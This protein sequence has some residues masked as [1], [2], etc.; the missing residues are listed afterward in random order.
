M[1][2]TA[3]E[4]AELA[5]LQG[6]GGAGHS[7][8]S[9][10]EHA[11]LQQLQ[12]ELPAQGTSLASKAMTGLKVGA[13]VL[14]YQRGAGSVALD[15][16]AQHMG[17]KPGMTDQQA[18]AALDPTS[19][20]VAPSYRELLKNW[21][22]PAGPSSKD[23]PR[24]MGILGTIAQHMP[25]VTARDAAGTGM[26]MGLDPMMYEGGALGKIAKMTEGVPYLGKAADAVSS[27]PSVA[28][29]ALKSGAKS[30]YESGIQPIIQA[31]KRFGNPDVGDTMMKHGIWGRP[32]SILKD[33]GET[34]GELKTSRDA[35][36]RAA[37]GLGATASKDDAITPMFQKLQQMV[38]DQRM[39]GPDAARILQDLTLSKQH[40]GDLVSPE[41]MT[42][43]KTDE[44][45]ALPGATFDAL[46]AR[47]PT[48]AQEI[49]RTLQGGYKNE[50]ERSVSDVVG[51]A[52]GQEFS[53]TNQELGDLINKKVKAAATGMANKH[54]KTPLLSA[55]DLMLMALGGGAGAAVG[56]T[57]GMTLEGGMGALATKKAIEALTSTAAKTG[58]GLG[59]T[60]ALNLP[61]VSPLLDAGVRRGIVDPVRRNSPYVIPAQ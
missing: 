12:S 11:E 33:M 23:V 10:D 7:K 54:E 2:L 51:P 42:V 46:R 49:R 28:S 14:D 56:H 8:L 53:T 43:W 20:D 22:V 57:A 27:L 35:T 38:K 1:A 31:G 6:S 59:A 39:T 17:A 5:D 34:A 52:A 60:R 36:L 55:A 29:D 21:G 45:K 15:R 37:T 58:A 24:H 50:V 48:M 3:A 61:G 44:G 30:L 41:L 16:I 32:T 47:S 4:Q 13:K 9:P 19:S 18:G 26:D 40:G 25:A